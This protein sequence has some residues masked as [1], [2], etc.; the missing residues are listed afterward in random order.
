MQSEARQSQIDERKATIRRAF[1]G[2]W[3]KMIAGWM[4]D[5]A[6]D[7]AWLMS[8]ASY[9]FR[10]HGL[11][12]AIDPVRLSQRLAEAPA[13]DYV[14]DLS[15]LS[16]VLLTHRHADHLDLGLLKSLKHL[17]I[18]WVIPEA[19]LSIVEREVE[20]SKKWL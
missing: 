4:Q 6:D 5:A 20:V 8:S 18:L 19:M 10:T 2:L 7:R 1:P 17:P 15:T 3:S 9:L 14:R 12:W 13:V 16:F 11:R